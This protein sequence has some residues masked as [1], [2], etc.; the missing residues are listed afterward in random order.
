M[1][2]KNSTKHRL[3]VDHCEQVPSDCRTRYPG[4]VAEREKKLTQSPL[5]IEFG[6][7]DVFLNGVTLP[8]HNKATISSE[9]YS[10]GY[11]LFANR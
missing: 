2:T 8:N 1:E 9:R 3:T 10:L 6:Q 7:C 4:R 11:R 5:Q